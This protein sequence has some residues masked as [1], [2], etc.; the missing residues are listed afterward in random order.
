M[1]VCSIHTNWSN[2]LLQ[3]YMAAGLF[4]MTARGRGFVI[5]SRA[6]LREGGLVNDTYGMVWYGRCL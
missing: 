5:N 2:S 3:V 6:P 1:H 4:L